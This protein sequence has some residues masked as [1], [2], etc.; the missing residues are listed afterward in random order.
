MALAAETGVAA[1]YVADNGIG[2][3]LVE[4]HGGTVRLDGSPGVGSTFA[5]TLAPPAGGL[6][7]PLQTEP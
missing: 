5:F 6:E 4:Q 3:K 2:K 7:R 1:F